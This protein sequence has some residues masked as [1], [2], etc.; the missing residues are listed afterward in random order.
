VNRTSLE[1]WKQGTQLFVGADIVSV[2][3]VTAVLDRFGDKYIRRTFT[4]REASYCRTASSAVAAQRFAA[5][6]AAKEA[7]LK[8]LQ[9]EGPWSNWRAIEVS[10]HKSGRCRL[11]L[12]GQAALLAAR[13]GIRCLALS[14]SHEGGVAAAVV[15]G[16]AADRTGQRESQRAARPHR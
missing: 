12:H 8:A 7:A 6:F 11:V 5:R 14:M 15:I 10:R 2:A 3:D 13:R 9:P 4:R 16:I 1:N